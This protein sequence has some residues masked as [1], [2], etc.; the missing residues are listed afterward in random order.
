VLRSPP[1]FLL[2]LMELVGVRAVR[3]EQTDRST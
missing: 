2:R 1:D 3:V